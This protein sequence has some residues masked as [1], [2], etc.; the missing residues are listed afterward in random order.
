[1]KLKAKQQRTM[2]IEGAGKFPSYFLL[3]LGIFQVTQHTCTNKKY[4]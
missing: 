1:M 3:I 2:S 4:P